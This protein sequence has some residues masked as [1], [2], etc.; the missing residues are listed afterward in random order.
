VFMAHHSKNIRILDDITRKASAL[1]AQHEPATLA[2][3]EIRFFDE[4]IDAIIKAS[5][6]PSHMT[7]E[8]AREK[9]LKARDEMPLIQ[10]DEANLLTKELRKA[11]KTVEVMG[12]IIK[13]RA[14]SLSKTNLEKIFKEAMDVHLRI[15]CYFLGLIRDE[16]GQKDLTD[17]IATRLEKISKESKKELSREKLEKASRTIFWNL[18]FF[19]VYGMIYKIVHSLGSDKLTEIV[20]RVCDER[21]TPSSFII[22]HGILMWYSK[23]LRTDEIVRRIGEEDF[24]QVAERAMELAI[25][26]HCALH[27]INYKDKQK[28]AKEL[29]IPIPKLLAASYKEP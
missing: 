2:K 11:V 9:R 4:H 27:E 7:P 26:N 23:N 3:S 13:N 14:G 28:I 25:A 19:V 5:L 12:C 15:M 22:K 24:S 21:N 18:N 17:Y 6:P 1:F 20:G 8:K 10:E 29:G 16:K